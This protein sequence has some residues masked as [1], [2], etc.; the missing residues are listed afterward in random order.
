MHPHR[1]T[2]YSMTCPICLRCLTTGQ[3]LTGKLAFLQNVVSNH[4]SSPL[5][6]HSFHLLPSPFP[7]LHITAPSLSPKRERERR[8]YQNTGGE[9][10]RNRPPFQSQIRSQ[11]K[12]PIIYRRLQRLRD[13]YVPQRH[14]EVGNTPFTPG[15]YPHRP[16]PL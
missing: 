13:R 3:K 14:Q 12:R 9:G 15:V 10:K 7:L 5:P 2:M 6:N 4:P 1:W 8:C 16:L 11:S